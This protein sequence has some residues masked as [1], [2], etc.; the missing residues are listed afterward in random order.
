MN[1]FQRSVAALAVLTLWGEGIVAADLETA[2]EIRD[3]ARRNFPEKTS[4]Q[5]IELK[6][7]D[8]A[9]SERVM[10]ARLHWKR[11][12]DGHVRLMIRVDG[13]Q[14]IK[15]SAYLVIENKPRDVV[16]MYLPALVRPRR[17]VG[18][19]SADIWGTDFSHEDLRLLQMSSAAFGSERLADGEVAGRPTYVV[20]QSSDPEAESAY[21]RIVSY[22]DHETCV[23]LQTEYYDANDQLHKRLLVNPETVAQV[24]GHWTAYDLEMTDVGEETSSW[25]HVKHISLDEDISARFFNTAQFYK[26]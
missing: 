1:R 15:G 12:D 23:S 6:S 25:I 22:I 16:Y 4:I 5:F 17:I 3:C 11:H 10:D 2:E 21:S 18:G 9:G 14:D 26:N 13:P 19:G 7:R 24:N 20:A 8:R